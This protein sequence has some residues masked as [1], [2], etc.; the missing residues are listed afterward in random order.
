MNIINTVKHCTNRVI[1][2]SFQ[3]IEEIVNF[4]KNPPV[5]H[6]NL[7]NQAR[8]L[9]KK[10]TEYGNIKRNKLPA[11]SMAF[12]F[13]KDYIKG[14]NIDSPTGYLYLDVDGKT[15]LDFEINT[16][17]V[18]ACWR[19]LSNTGIALVVKVEGLTT[20]NLKPATAEIA[21]LLDIPYDPKAVSIDR[22]TVLPYDPNAYYNDK[23]DIIPIAK[24]LPYDSEVIAESE[25]ST[26][27]NTINKVNT[28]GYEC[29]GYKLRFNN[30]NE[31][32]QPLN[33][34]FD[35]NGF[36]DLGKDNKLKYAQVFIPFRT[37]N[38]GERE[39]I[40]K[41]IAYQLI[42]LNK[43]APKYLLLKYLQ[44]VNAK[45]MRPQ[46]SSTEVNITFNKVYKKRKDIQ[47]RLSTNRRFFYDGT[48]TTTEKRKL[49]ASQ[50]GK[51]KV[52][53]TTKELLEIMSTWDIEKYGKITIDKVTEVSGKDKKTVQKYYT[54]LKKQLFDQEKSILQEMDELLFWDIGNAA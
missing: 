4:I 36:Y 15:E 11:V 31:L 6:I 19:S 7:V 33:I 14:E 22:L 51:D 21:R 10:S 49:N 16:T 32:L 17:Y 37:V 40:L 13:S 18:C 28:I 24:L 1:T 25:K 30:L 43:D 50:I 47:P 29:N 53:K 26:H 45:I 41:S 9:D 52:I 8:S 42:A 20:D 2:G 46:L 5:E 35:E 44:I 23:T 27:F 34:Q 39:S 48:L 54:G 12:N 3:D 38:T